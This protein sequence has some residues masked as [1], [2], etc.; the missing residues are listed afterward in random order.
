VILSA[1]PA[2]ADALGTSVAQLAGAGIS[3]F[4]VEPAQALMRLRSGLRGTAEPFVLRSRDGRRFSCEASPLDSDTVLLRL[5]GGPDA[6]LRARNL[7]EASARLQTFTDADN[8]EM[9]AATARG[10]LDRMITSV[11]ATWASVHVI[12]TSGANLELLAH[13]SAPTEYIDR[14]RLLPLSAPRPVTDALTQNTPMYLETVADFEARYPRLAAAHPSMVTFAKACLPLSVQGRVMGV[15]TLA[16]ASGYRF[17]AAARAGLDAFALHCAQALDHARPSAAERAARELAEEQA[18]ARLERLH[19]FTGAL[20]QAITPAEVAEVVV[21]L[22]LSAVS[23]NAGGFWQVSQDGASVRLMRSVGSGVPRSEQ[24]GELPLGVPGK[25]PVLDAIRSSTPVWIESARQM[26]ERYP[27]FYAQMLQQGPCNTALACLPLLAQGRC[28]AGLTYRFDSPHWFTE[29]ERAFLQLVSWYAAQAFERARL[30]ASEKLAREAAVA[31]QRRAEFLANAG[32][33]LMS[34]LDHRST[35]AGLAKAAVPSVADWC[36]V[37]LA[38]SMTPVAAHTD[39]SKV[40]TVLALRE[41]RRRITSSVTGIDTVMKSGQPIV[42]REITRPML[43]QFAPDP[44]YLQFALE[45]GVTSAM[46]VPIVAR[47]RVLGTILLVS[48]DPARLYGDQ[49]LAMAEELARRAGLAVDNALL[50]SEAREADQRKDEFLAMLGHELRNPIAPLRA[51]LDLMSLQDSTAFEHERTV[52]QRQVEHLTGLVDDLLDVSRITRGKIELRKVHVDVARVITS[53]VEIASPALE[54]RAHQLAVIPGSGLSVLA[55][56]A[57]MSQAIANLL[58][59]AAKFTEP[60]GR[61][62]ITAERA[63]DSVVI[64]V[65]DSGIG[66]A[67]DMLQ[68]IFDPFFQGTGARESSHGGLGLG[69]AIVASLVKL[70]GG[71]VTAHSDGIGHGSEFVI[72]LALAKEPAANAP[73]AVV[74]AHNATNTAPALRVLIVDDNDDAASAIAAVLRFLGCSVQV[75]ADGPSALASLPAAAPD[76]ALLDIGLPVMDGYELVRRLRALPTYADTYFVAITGYGQD[77]D[78][79]NALEAGF[80]DHVVKPIGLARLRE[81]IAHCRERARTRA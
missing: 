54:H 68:Q 63:G 27:A 50:Y 55:D 40:A 75:A 41:Y 58:T 11:G 17:D 49:D 12:D 26:E 9:L 10:S 3:T 32:N 71:T 70:H 44:E 21:D 23:A 67:K 29:H 51:A 48:S 59:N 7:L 13:V 45:V 81:L 72:R 56:P 37:E 22:G 52:M 62:Y 43:D 39:P 42:F 14:V 34:S 31:S 33:L 38:G 60:G 4:A 6:E 53:A 15:L 76:L 28:V 25:M 77:A 2:G 80:E 19:A 74:P 8:A 47:G 64:A 1:N 78:R 18:L 66:I 61:I 73:R 65:K 16:F 46:V 30:Y 5:S 24:L 36:V 35:L 79:R 69:L 57:R 20:A